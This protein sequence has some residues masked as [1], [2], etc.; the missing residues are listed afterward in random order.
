MFL[1]VYHVYVYIKNVNSIRPPPSNLD[2]VLLR[3][4]PGNM[5]CHM[6][7]HSNAVLLREAYPM[8]GIVSTNAGAFSSFSNFWKHIVQ[9]IALKQVCCPY[10]SPLK[11]SLQHLFEH[12]QF[13]FEQPCNSVFPGQTWRKNWTYHDIPTCR[14]KKTPDPFPPCFTS[15]LVSLKRALQKFIPTSWV[16]F[17]S[18]TVRTDLSKLVRS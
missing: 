7:Q 5:S 15:K 4:V 2:D 6:F 18:S 3:L 12:M 9:S 1:D 13:G 8:P 14:T 10:D 11:A 16:A 17:A